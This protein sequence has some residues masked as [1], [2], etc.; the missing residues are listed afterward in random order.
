VVEEAPGRVPRLVL[1]ARNVR[2]EIGAALGETEKRDLAAAL[3][4][5]LH[6]RRNPTFE[7]SQLREHRNSCD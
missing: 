3:G 4:A 6:R 5:A 7:N 1:T 2:E